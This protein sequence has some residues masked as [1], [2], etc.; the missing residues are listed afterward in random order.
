MEEGGFTLVGKKG[1]P[2]KPHRVAAVSA[3]AA[4]M[5]KVTTA[6][7]KD[8]EG[9]TSSTVILP[10]TCD[11]SAARVKNIGKRLSKATAMLRANGYWDTLKKALASAG[12][13]EYSELVSF[14]IGNFCCSR[15]SLLQFSVFLL[16]K[17][18]L[19]RPD[20]VVSVYDPAF[21]DACKSVCAQH[22]IPVTEKD[23]RAAHP[24]G[25]SGATLFYMPHCDLFMYENVIAANSIEDDGG[26]SNSSSV[27][28]RA[29]IVG[30]SFSSYIERFNTLSAQQH[31][32]LAGCEACLVETPVVFASPASGLS[33][34]SIANAFNNTSV[35]RFV[36][37]AAEPET[38]KKEEN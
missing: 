20:T 35:H 11:S 13:Q 17:E 7:G 4:R 31:P 22:G 16:L 25:C 33:D 10:C 5:V 15:V 37:K 3:K 14:G 18:E 19:C 6:T 2:C 23:E 21:G 34:H 8:G 27:D 38:T 1:K 28:P 26:D 32:H 9:E 29:V 30:N 24:C 12:P 36:K